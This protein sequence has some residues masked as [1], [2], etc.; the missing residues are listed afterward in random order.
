MLELLRRVVLLHRCSSGLGIVLIVSNTIRLDILNRRAEI[1]VMKLV[2]ASDGFARRPFLYSGVW[3]GLGGG[4]AGAACWSAW[5]P[6][7]LAGR[8]RSWPACTAASSVCAGLDL[9]S[10]AGGTGAIGRPVAG[11]VPGLLPRAISERSTHKRHKSLDCI[12]FYW[13]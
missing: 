6:R 7:L 5:P 2:G 11:P 3:Y 1:E 12:I 9:A 10:A 13:I 4:I 8:S